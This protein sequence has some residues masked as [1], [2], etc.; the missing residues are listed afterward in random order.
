M[1]LRSKYE[2]NSFDNSDNGELRMSISGGA[3]F[4]KLLISL[5]IA[6]RGELISALVDGKGR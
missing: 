2:K 5:H 1:R 6:Y 4:E 3:H